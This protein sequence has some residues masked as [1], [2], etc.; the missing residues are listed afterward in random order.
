MAIMRAS[1][2]REKGDEELETDLTELKKTLM[3]I[4][5]G[6]ASGGI[7]EDVGKTREIKKT[8]SRILT[9]KR[10][11]ELGLEKKQKTMPPTE[12]E[13]AAEKPQDTID[14]NKT[15]DKK[16]V[17]KTKTPRRKKKKEVIKKK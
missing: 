9:I 2:V 1:E 6:L 7:P 11:R 5:G 16:E 3:K 8:I 17:K 14:K 4:R 10:E 12:K 15:D 13:A